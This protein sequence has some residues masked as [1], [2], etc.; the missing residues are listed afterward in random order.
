[1]PSRVAQDVPYVGLEHLPRRSTT[2][3]DYGAVDN[4]SSLKF[5][6]QKWD[7]LFGKIRPYF[8]KVSVAPF[9]GICS[10]DTIVMRPKRSDAQ[11][12]LI[13]IASS[14]RFVAHSV[15]TSNGTKMP[16][17]NWPVLSRYPVPIPPPGMLSTYNR[18]VVDAAN[19]AATFQA[20]N[21][22]LQRA[23]DLLLP[24][25]V[26]GDLAVVAAEQELADAA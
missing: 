6:F 20:T 26:S 21:V 2:L 3:T 5:R 24:R 15:T 13:S 8:H 18:F 4:V 9:D 22:G 14:D 7:V 16:R 11:G 19:A 12:M 10:S 1:M 25:L 23:R 17:A